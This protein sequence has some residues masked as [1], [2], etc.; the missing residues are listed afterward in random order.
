MVQER[1]LR[2]VDTCPAGTAF[3]KCAIGPF[4][5]CCSTN[6]CDTGVCGDVDDCD[7]SSMAG[8]QGS[9]TTPEQQP[10]TLTV[11]VSK[12]IASLTT[13]ATISDVIT[14]VVTK[15]ATATTTQGVLS[16]PNLPAAT[17]DAASSIDSSENSSARSPA[18]PPASS[19]LSTGSSISTENPVSSLHATA[20]ANTSTTIANL[21]NMTSSSWMK[22]T[23]PPATPAKNPHPNTSTVIGGIV[24]ALC[25][26]ALL[27]L[28]LLCCCFRRKRSNTHN[29]CVKRSTKEGD[30]EQKRAELLRRAE[31]AALER[32]TFLGGRVAVATTTGALSPVRAETTDNGAS[33]YPRNSSAGP[34]QHWI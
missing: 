21:S 12:V 13:T 1:Y 20:P 32:E 2:Q 14:S 10:V 11:T 34:P 4:T 25:L 26:V 18:T 27:A 8:A 28:L 31:E 16:L 29:F 6:P 15:T 22:Q 24:G 5:G 7:S 33:T 17:S 19:H 30:E 9:S 23:S 3:Y